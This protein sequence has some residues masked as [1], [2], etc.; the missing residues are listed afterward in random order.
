[1]FAVVCTNSAVAQALGA[2]SNNDGAPKYDRSGR[3][4]NVALATSGVAGTTVTTD[5]FKRQVMRQDWLGMRK[6]LLKG[7]AI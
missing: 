2:A 7:I 3:F 6:Q 4:A 5:F 1:M